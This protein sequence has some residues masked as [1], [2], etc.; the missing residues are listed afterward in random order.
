[1]ITPP[2]Q[3]VQNCYWNYLMTNLKI[4]CIWCPSW[5]SH[6]HHQRS[7][8]MSPGINSGRIRA[9]VDKRIADK[10]A[11][12]GMSRPPFSEWL[13]DPQE[14]S[15]LPRASS[16][17]NS[18]PPHT[19]LLSSLSHMLYPAQHETLPQN[20]H[21]ATHSSQGVCYW[22]SPQQKLCRSKKWSEKEEE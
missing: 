2:H 21:S 1:M 10:R 12:M 3:E 9:S 14:P 7:S 6:H 19:I 5:R 18:Y 15:L 20:I 13:F 11:R 8:W 22:Y 16:L 17:Y 4:W